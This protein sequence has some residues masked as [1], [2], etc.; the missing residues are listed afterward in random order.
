M[1]RFSSAVVA[2]FAAAVFVL[3]G[4]S[5]VSKVTNQGGDT[6]CK[7]FKGQDNDKQ[8]SEVSKMLKDKNGSEPS[9]MELSATRMAVD[10]YCK[11]L[12]KDSSKISE[13][14]P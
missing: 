1:T 10:A 5:A 7:D 11:T 8:E 2:V 13:A 14:T 4:C 9:N 3:G 12:G 6:T